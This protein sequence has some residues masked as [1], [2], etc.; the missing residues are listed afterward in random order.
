M[1][2]NQ[3]VQREIV[4]IGGQLRAVSEGMPDAGQ[5]FKFT[6]E[7]MTPRQMIEH[8]CEAYTAVLNIASGREHRWGEYQAEDKDYGKLLLTMWD[9]RR[10]AAAAVKDDSSDK[11]AETGYDY[12]VAHDAYH[13]GQMALVRMHVDPAWD[14]HSIYSEVPAAI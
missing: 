13:V 14:P 3:M 8:L 10:Q 1:T 6:A 5:D 4:N 11:L 7:A 9:L 12:I 2:A